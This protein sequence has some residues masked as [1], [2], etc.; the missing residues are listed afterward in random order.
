MDNATQSLLQ[1]IG[2]V[3]WWLGKWR[4]PL[5][6]EN[7]DIKL[8]ADGSFETFGKL[9]INNGSIWLN[10]ATGVLDIKKD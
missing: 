10:L 6:Y 7:D 2:K 5:V 9:N 8:N 4:S 1:Y 3:G